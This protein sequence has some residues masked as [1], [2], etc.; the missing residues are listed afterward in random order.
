MEEI[1]HLIFEALRDGFIWVDMSGRLKKFNSAYQRMLGYSAQELLNLTY[2]DITPKKWHAFEEK[3]IQEQVMQRGYSDLYEKEY[4]TK[5]GRVFPVELITYL[6]KGKE[7]KPVGMWA[8][9]RDIS[10]RRKIIEELSVS[11]TRCFDLFENANDMIYTFDL[12][13]NFTSLN[14]STCDTLGYSKDELI[15]KNIMDVLSLESRGFAI[16]M[17]QQAIADKSD[18]KELQPWEFVIVRKDGSEVIS[19][20]RTRLIWEEKE[21]VGVQG[22]SRDISERKKY[23]EDLKKKIH[24][25]EIFNKISIERELKMIELKKK[26]EELEYKLKVKS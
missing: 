19:E 24:D 6:D 13:G 2:I 15:K 21:V 18:L 7:G 11:Q 22:I 26:I 9:V 3:I 1:Y 16:K 8:F 23:E 10:E 20:T 25:L 17:L 4:V 12:A 5:D 14:R